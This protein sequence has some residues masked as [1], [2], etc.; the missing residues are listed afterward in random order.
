MHQDHAA[1]LR[2]ASEYDVFPQIHDMDD[3]CF[4]FEESDMLGEE[5]SWGRIFGVIDGYVD[6]ASNNSSDIVREWT[7][8]PEIRCGKAAQS[9]WDDNRIRSSSVLGR[10]R[11]PYRDD[12]GLLHYLVQAACLSK[13]PVILLY[14]F[15]PVVDIDVVDLHQRQSA[16]L[17]PIDQFEGGI[18]EYR[19]RDGDEMVPGWQM[20]EG[21]S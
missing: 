14:Q 3:M 10:F 11:H 1:E 8:D 5:T 19:L 15:P 20:G 13:I 9:G 2:Q 4:E 21:C 17:T 12:L 6:M 18:V 16:H 7:D